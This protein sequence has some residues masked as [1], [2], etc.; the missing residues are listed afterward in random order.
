MRCDVSLLIC[1]S[2]YISEKVR[3]NPFSALL[4]ISQ[5]VEQGWENSEQQLYYAHTYNQL[6]MVIV[7]LYFADICDI[8]RSSIHCSCFYIYT[9]MYFTLVEIYETKSIEIVA[10]HIIKVHS[11]QDVFEVAFVVLPD[12]GWSRSQASFFGSNYMCHLCTCDVI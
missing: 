3:K 5:D 4:L 6:N 1:Y 11:W 10:E 8:Y 2:K 7:I 12:K 9:F